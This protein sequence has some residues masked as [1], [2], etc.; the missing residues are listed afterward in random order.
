MIVLRIIELADGRPTTLHG[1]FVHDFDADANDGIG[2]IV[3]TPVI[4]RAKQ[5]ESGKEATEFWK[6]QSAV[7]PLRP[8]GKPN[9]PLTA[10]TVELVTFEPGVT[11][12]DRVAGFFRTRS[13]FR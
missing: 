10:F 13:K 11:H 9:R 6:T 12:D 4:D 7:R 2:V 5:F 1:Q 3:A 8:D